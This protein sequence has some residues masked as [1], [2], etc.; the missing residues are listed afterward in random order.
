MKQKPHK[1]NDLLW[2]VLADISSSPSSFSCRHG[3]CGVPVDWDICA[4]C[5]GRVWHWRVS[6]P[7]KKSILTFMLVLKTAIPCS[8]YRRKQW[9]LRFWRQACVVGCQ[10]GL[11]NLLWL[12]SHLPFLEERELDSFLWHTLQYLLHHCFFFH[13]DVGFAFNILDLY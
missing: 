12:L 5:L 11:K 2:F 13:R 8:L 1:C 10:S 3:E 9:F 6:W 7:K 4:S